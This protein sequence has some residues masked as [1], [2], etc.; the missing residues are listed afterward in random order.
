MCNKHLFV[1]C[2]SR[3]VLISSDVP[4]T[5]VPVVLTTHQ[6]TKICPSNSWHL[7]LQSYTFSPFPPRWTLGNCHCCIGWT[8]ISQAFTLKEHLKGP[9]INGRVPGKN[10]RRNHNSEEEKSYLKLPIFFGKH[11][12]HSDQC[13]SADPIGWSDNVEKIIFYQAVVRCELRED[14]G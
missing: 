8:K 11:S 3:V 5:V 4:C 1:S 7:L 13:S 14:A 6:P 9:A 2:L 10:S 12:I